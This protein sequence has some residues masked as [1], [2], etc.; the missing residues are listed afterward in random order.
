MDGM[1]YHRNGMNA[2][3]N[4]KK[5]VQRSRVRVTFT[6]PEDVLRCL[7]REPNKSRVVETALRKHYGVVP[8]EVREWL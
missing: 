2:S 7:G 3:T 4:T 8:D 6:L 1:W 5:R